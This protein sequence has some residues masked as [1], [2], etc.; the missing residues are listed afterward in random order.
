MNQSV[1][2]VLLEKVDAIPDISIADVDAPGRMD[3]MRCAWA[4]AEMAEGISMFMSVS[5]S[6]DIS[7]DR[8]VC[9][10]VSDGKKGGKR[11]RLLL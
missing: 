4:P 7:G 8:T 9:L 3:A 1:T 10:N 2:R 5:V 6:I 11:G